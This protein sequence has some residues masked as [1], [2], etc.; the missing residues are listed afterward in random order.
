MVEIVRAVTK[1]TEVVIMD[2]PTASLTDEET[3][4]L[5]RMVQKIKETGVSI[6]FISHRLDEVIRISDR[7]TVLR[8]GVLIGCLEKAEIR[9]K[10][11]LVNMMIR[12]RPSATLKEDDKEIGSVVLK[13]QNLC[14]K[15]R[16]KNL[17]L[18]LYQGEVL[19]IAGLV[20]AGRT[21]LLKTIFGVYT[22]TDGEIVV[23]EKVYRKLGIRQAVKLGIAYMPEDRKGE[24]L[25]LKMSVA[26]N[27]IYA[28]LEFYCRGGLLN[29]KRQRQTV[30][31]MGRQLRLKAGSVR[32]Q[33]GS[34]SGGNQQ[35]IV[36]AKWLIAQSSIILMDEPTRGIDVGAKGEIYNLVRQLARE[37]KSVIFVSS[38]LEE[39]QT[40]SDR[41]LVMREGEITK[42]LPMNST[43]EEMMRYAV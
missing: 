11:Q 24:G 42:E 10:D 31:E 3:Q 37:G 2:E 25:L 29:T 28:G 20:G 9:D 12:V 16:L 41:I 33:A 43:V 4:T 36:I 40:V 14:Y 5:F 21:E 35:K 26:D 15:N 17:N 38:E 34:L 22:P 39:I 30:E 8:D 27:E 1:N 7:V 18:S 32:D 23:G 6:I 19:G 13:T